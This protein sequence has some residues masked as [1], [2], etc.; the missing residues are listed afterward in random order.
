[1]SVFNRR[2][3]M[4]LGGM[5][6]LISMA[7]GNAFSRSQPDVADLNALQKVVTF[8][9]DGIDMTTLEYSHLLFKLAKRGGIKA[10]YYCSD[11]IVEEL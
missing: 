11:G 3:F 9:G 6:A 5:A 10:D 4:K 8:S 7:G 1:M 2:E